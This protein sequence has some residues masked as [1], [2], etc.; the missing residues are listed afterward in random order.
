M[1]DKTLTTPKNV[2]PASPDDKAYR[3][4][5][6]F[7]VADD[8]GAVFDQPTPL[9]LFVDW[10]ELA[11]TYEPNDPNAMSL[12]TLDKNGMPDVRVVLLKDISDQGLSF[13]TNLESAKGAALAQ[14]PVAA[15][16]F[17]WK[18]IRRQIR[19][20]GRVVPV[21]DEAADRYFASRARGAQIGAWVSSQS[22]RLEDPDQLKTQIDEYTAAHEGQ[23]I[24]RP[25]HWGGFLIIPT[26]FEFWVNRPYRL[27]DRL[28]FERNSNASEWE[29]FWLYP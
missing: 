14:N 7:G 19:V 8:Q 9:S 25:P 11:K 22:R 12:A 20:Q 21:D 1:P 16:C 3:Q 4:E 27:H 15:T 5:E 13:Y 2:I 28:I 17:H 6:A 10:F 29:K 23:E 18:S 24:E 26:R